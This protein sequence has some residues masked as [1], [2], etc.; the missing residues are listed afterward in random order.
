MRTRGKNFSGGFSLVELTVATA[1]FS[2][3]LSSLSL[4]MLTAVRGTD[5]AH[6]ETIATTHAESLAAVIAMNTDALGHFIHP[7]AQIAAEC[8]ETDCTPEG[9]AAAA[10]A[11][12]Q[13]AVSQDL[14]D[15]MA[16]VCRD[17]LIDDG[18][19]GNPMC[20]DSG[21]LAIKIFWQD[22]GQPDASERTKR[23]VLRLPW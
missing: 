23:Y 20:D 13:Q 1:I 5:N 22:A 4:M 7:V 12:W 16:V 18:G 19:P 11:G 9:S 10:M 3:G 15:G 6:H 8:F 2:I 21:N 17:A 14:P